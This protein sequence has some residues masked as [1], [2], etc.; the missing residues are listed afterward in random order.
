MAELDNR[1]ITDSIMKNYMYADWVKTIHYAT[2]S[3]H[4]HELCDKVRDDIVDFTDS[5]AEQFFGFHGK[6]EV[7]D[8]S[9][10]NNIV[11][12]PNL[13]DICEAVIDIANEI[14]EGL[15]DDYRGWSLQ[16]LIDDFVGTMG[17]NKFLCR[18]Q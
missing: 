8:F 15:P 3:N 18:L 1:L 17:Q 10:E 16:S 5:L 13:Q 4:I 14:R 6:P 7:A 2:T 9:I 11:K 12:S